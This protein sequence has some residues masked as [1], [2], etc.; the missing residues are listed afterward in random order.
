MKIQINRKNIRG[1]AFATLALAALALLPGCANEENTT[2]KGQGKLSFTLGGITEGE[3]ETVTRAQAAPE[4]VTQDLGGDLVIT[5]TL[6]PDATSKTKAT[7]TMTPG[8]NY[9]LVV[10][11]ASNNIVG[12][13]DGVAGT[14]TPEIPVTVGDSYT[15]VAYSYNASDALIL[16]DPGAAGSAAGTIPAGAGID[17]LYFKTSVTGA[18][19]TTLVPINFSHKYSQVKV[20][21]DASS[22]APNVTDASGF[23]L[24]PSYPTTLDLPT[25]AVAKSGTTSTPVAINFG[26]LNAQTVTSFA[27]TLFSNG[28]TPLTLA[29]GSLTIGGTTYTNKTVT[30][31]RPLAAGNSYTLTVNVHTLIPLSI[32]LAQSQ[33]YFLAS[34]YDQDYLPYA[35]PTSAATTATS[36]ADGGNEPYVIDYQGSITTSGITVQIPVTAT[37][38]GTLPP[39]STTIT[40]PSSL[41]QGGGSPVDLNLSWASQAY[42]SSTK[43]ITATIKAVGSTLNAIKLDVNAGIGNDYLGVLLGQFSYPYNNAGNTTTYSVRGIAGIPDRMFGV[44]DNT[45]NTTTHRMLYL[46]AVSEGGS[47]WLNN[48]LGADY[49][50][51]NKASFNPAQQATSQ[52][53]YL[54]CGSLFQWGRKPDGHELIN[55]ASGSGSTAV[56]GTTSTNADNPAHA[57]FIKVTLTPFDWRANQDGTLW[58]TEASANNPCPAGFKLPSSGQLTGLFSVITEI[59]SA[60]SCALKLPAAGLRSLAGT[61]SFQGSY[62]YYW[63]N[64]PNG[65]N[66]SQRNF[67]T[68]GTGVG[69]S[70]RAYGYSVRCIKN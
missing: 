36:P 3:S 5:Y 40:V 29:V 2:G 46:P 23:T 53:D 21:V 55:R 10:L 1:A 57:L 41:I 44:A 13:V 26:T 37:A 59:A 12:S 25:G 7:S 64:S 33:K 43:Y 17:L 31:T 14:Q 16:P 47:I 20:V 56:N 9:K 65:T 49:A 70:N 68:G 4:T 42:T 22:L 28:E 60:A 34:M 24:D 67:A 11:D 8:N 61:V 52:S 30:F 54:A 51:T 35:A 45:G 15:V 19:G 69:L 27:A 48:N 63:S 18:S 6:T 50:N 39:Y 32:T 66:A 58:A 62:G 38:D